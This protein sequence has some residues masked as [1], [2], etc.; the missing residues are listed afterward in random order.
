MKVSFIGAGR[1]AMT[2]ALVLNKKETVEEIHMWEFS[3]ERLENINNTRKIPDLPSTIS[4]P[5]NIIVSSNLEQ[6]LQSAEIIVFA[7]PSQSLRSVL[8]RISPFW[9]SNTQERKNKITNQSAVLVSAIKGLENNTTKRMSEVI[10]EFFPDLKI[11]TLAGP[12]IPLEIVEE[13]PA[14]LV[15]ASHRAD[16][17]SYIQELLS[18]KNLRIY[19]HNDI[20]G[21]ELGGALKNVIAIAGGICD[22]LKLGDNAKAALLTRGLVEITRLGIALN[23]NPMTFAGLSG[24]GD[25][26][27][28]SYSPFSRNRRL[29]EMIAQGVN[30]EDT[31]K[32]LS[33]VAEG[34][35]TTIS[36]KSIASKMRLELPIIEEI[37]TIL[38]KNIEIN[39]SI[40][41]LMERPLKKEMNY[42]G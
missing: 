37:H 26:I 36:A 24:I 15:V 10:K 33:G 8:T 23:A 19:T 16:A 41:R 9:F 2:L 12:G 20:V 25:I 4:I 6:V 13:K 11:V 1:W 29:G 27:V 30:L 34:V 31:T 35:A 40:K 28:T 39:K 42:E 22:G 5:N 32:S 14:S 21:V 7:V 17:A 3:P 18:Y 38:Y